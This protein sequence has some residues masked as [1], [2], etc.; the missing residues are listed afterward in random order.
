LWGVIAI[1]VLSVPVVA[2]AYTIHGKI[3]NGSRGDAPVDVDVL[4]IN[5]SAG[6][7]PEQTVTAK[8][9][10]FTVE[11]LSDASRV[12]LLRVHYDGVDYSLPIQP[13]AGHASVTIPVYDKTTSW[14]GVRVD[15]PQ[16]VARRAGDELVIERIYEVVNATNPPVTVQGSPFRITLPEGHHS[17]DGVFISAL[18]MPVE[19]PA[20]PSDA[21]NIYE[22]AYPIRPG[23]TRMGMSYTIPYPDGRFSL[24]EEN[25][26]D[27]GE[28]VVISTDPQ[29]KVSSNTIVFVDIEEGAQGLVS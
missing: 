14:D 12:Y 29:L 16:L 17:F 18:G 7:L 24:V 28:L 19:R 25:L 1:A 6:M 13:S 20:T 3:V 8:D 27:I 9:G 10:A 22:I 15:V 4:V 5:P 2:T 23:A 11:G 26:Y 21:P